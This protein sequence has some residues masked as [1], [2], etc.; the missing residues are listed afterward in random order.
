MARPAPLAV[1]LSPAFRSSPAKAVSDT[2]G[3]GITTCCGMTAMLAPF[4]LSTYVLSVLL[5]ATVLLT[6]AL[7]MIVLAVAVTIAC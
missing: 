5:V 3:Y 4:A 6:M 2:D 7:V 1:M